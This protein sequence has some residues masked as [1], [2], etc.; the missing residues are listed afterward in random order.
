[1]TRQDK[2]KSAAGGLDNGAGAGM[3]ERGIRPSDSPRD[4]GSRVFAL[5]NDELIVAAETV[6]R[7]QRAVSVGLGRAPRWPDSPECERNITNGVDRLGLPTVLGG[8]SIGPSSKIG[9][10]AF[11][12]LF[13]GVQREVLF[14]ARPSGPVNG[15]IVGSVETELEFRLVVHRREIDEQLVERRGELWRWRQPPTT[16]RVASWGN[17]GR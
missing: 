12:H 9:Q 17:Y 10:G 4:M 2:A 15:S 7:W 5:F 6:G 3:A 1:M 13:N 14:K 11:I 16:T 8:E